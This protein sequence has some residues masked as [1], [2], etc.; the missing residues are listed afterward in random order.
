[1]NHANLAH[2]LAKFVAPEVLAQL[3]NFTVGVEAYPQVS[4]AEAELV[5]EFHEALCEFAPEAMD[6]ARN[7]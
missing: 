3:M 4:D 1:M 2:A 7:A 5:G 6:I